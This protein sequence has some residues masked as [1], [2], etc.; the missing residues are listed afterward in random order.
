L[1]QYED[2]DRQPACRIEVGTGGAIF[3]N[4]VDPNLLHVLRRSL[5]CI[6][7]AAA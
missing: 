2:E 4:H 1:V 6:G 7:L 3:L 5:G